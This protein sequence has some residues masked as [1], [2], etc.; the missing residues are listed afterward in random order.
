M[1]TSGPTSLCSALPVSSSAPPSPRN[2]SWREPAHREQRQARELEQAARPER[3]R[4]ADRAA[5]RRDRRRHR[6]EQRIA[7]PLEARRRTSRHASPSPGANSSSDAAVSS[8]SVD[9]TAHR[10]SAVGC[11]STSGARRQRSP[12]DGEVERAHDRRRDAERVERAEEVVHEAGMGELGAAHRAARLGLRLEHEHPPA[13]VGEQVGGDQPVR[14]RPDHDRVGSHGSRRYRRPGSRRLSGRRVTLSTVSRRYR[15]KYPFPRLKSRGTRAATVLPGAHLPCSPPGGRSPSPKPKRL[16]ARAPVGT[17]QPKGTQPMRKRMLL[18][19]A[20]LCVVALAAGVAVA[21]PSA[22]SR[23]T[24]RNST[25]P[26]RCGR[27]PLPPVC[28]K[29]NALSAIFDQVGRLRAGRSS[30][31]NRLLPP[32][33]LGTT[34][35]S[36]APSRSG[37]SRRRRAGRTG[38]LD[39]DDGDFLS[40]VRQRES[41]GDYTVHNYPGLRRLRRVPVHAGHLELDRRVRRSRRPRRHRSRGSSR[42]PTRTPW[43]LRSTPSRAPRHGAAPAEQRAGLRGQRATS[44]E[45][46]PPRRHER[47]PALRVR[48]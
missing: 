17:R 14:A 20:P 41:G 6:V 3:G 44:S 8:T 11:A 35:R 5:H 36:A 18:I 34:P 46:S 21:A 16:S 15:A 1:A 12:C 9:S 30:S 39:Q 7:D 33:E 38:L 24:M 47:G 43:P 10:P 19:V 27:S 42:P 32:V 26:M 37:S 22:R 28:S 2:C 25:T 29:P 23:S 4:E 45:P 13:G 40:C 31:C 48:P